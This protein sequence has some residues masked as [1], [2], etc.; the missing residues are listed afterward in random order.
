MISNICTAL[1]FHGRDRAIYHFEAAMA[2]GDYR[3]GRESQLVCA[4]AIAI[5][6]V[7]EKK[8]EPIARIAVRLDLKSFRILTLITGTH[9]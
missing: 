8:P 1:E 7:E 9:W 6:M 3:W 4:V 2:N 5:S